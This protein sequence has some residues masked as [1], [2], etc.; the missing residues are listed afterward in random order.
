MMKYKIED[1]EIEA[2]KSYRGFN[3]EQINQLLTSNC[4]TDIELLREGENNT[5]VTLSYDR[6]NVIKNM[7]SIKKLYSLI[8]KSYLNKDELSEF[9]FYRG[10]N[11]AEIARIKNEPYIDRM[12]SVVKNE[13]KAREKYASKWDSPVVI[14]VKGNEQIPFIKPSDFF[15]NEDHDEVIIVPFTQIKEIKDLSIGTSFET[16]S[17]V[18]KYEIYI[19]RQ[20][21]EKLSETEKKGL[22]TYITNNVENINSYLVQCLAIDKRTEENR[23]NLKKLDQLLAKY[24]LGGTPESNFED[25]TPRSQEDLEDITRISNEIENIKIA[26]GS[27]YDVRKTLVNSITTWK[28]NV[29]LYL[30]SECDEISEALFSEQDNNIEEK[31][32]KAEEPEEEESELEEKEEEIVSPSYKPD[33]TMA[34]VEETSE[35]E[36]EE[37]VKE[38]PKE[39]PKEEVQE[40]L[41]EEEIEEEPVEEAKEEKIEEEQKESVSDETI[42]AA[43]IQRNDEDEFIAHSRQLVRDNEALVEKLEE[44]I[45]GLITKEQNHAK[46]AGNIGSTYSAINNGFEMKKAAEALHEQIKNIKLKVEALIEKNDEFSREKL[47]NINE[48]NNQVTVL[49]NYLNN[50]RCAIPG[51]DITRF[52]EMAI[53]E[54]NALKRGIEIKIRDI[55]AEAEIRKLNEDLE[56]LDS[57]PLFSRIIGI[58]SG[59][60]KADDIAREQILVR[61][62]AIR[63]K[64]SEKLLLARNYSIHNMVAKIRLF[65]RDNFEDETVEDTCEEIQ[66]LE[67]ELKRNFVINDTRVEE[68]VRKREGLDLP[69]DK[70]LSREEEKE[71]ETFRFLRKYEYDMIDENNTE[72]SYQDT[73]ASEISRVIDYI[74]STNILK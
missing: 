5:F 50:P 3:Y 42:V 19:E 15:E 68:I 51:T 58:F 18:R 48:I 55:L 11:V 52:D 12:F 4:E 72:E 36:P 8:I 28:R 31:V 25:T 44:D 2:L 64:T 13:E 53:I 47:R 24:N 73:L 41:K 60:N 40:E 35:K 57:K 16:Y 7:E 39:E 66:E 34:A 37:E 54:E 33:F 21:L 6:E 67:N 43:P 32:V 10:T 61:K 1:D 9:S 23:S 46:V 45:K 69:L 70:N 63:R 49:I 65:I 22:Y 62:Q 27:D 56:V 74:S 38:E 26:I 20:K 30:M 17:E 59:S 71:I 29:I 14:N